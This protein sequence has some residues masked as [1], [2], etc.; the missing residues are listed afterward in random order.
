MNY[1]E[2][3]CLL[4]KMDRTFIRDTV[5]RVDQLS[6]RPDPS[7]VYSPEEAKLEPVLARFFSIS[8]VVSL[9]NDLR[10]LNHDLTTA[11]LIKYMERAHFDAMAQYEQLTLEI[12]NAKLFEY[13][14]RRVVPRAY[15]VRALDPRPTVVTMYRRADEVER[16]GAR[17]PF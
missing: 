13:V 5:L 16:S 4:N 12:L 1:F 10:L 11:D 7:Q 17:Q 9:Q 6:Y 14:Q 8:N 15:T 3:H 2:L